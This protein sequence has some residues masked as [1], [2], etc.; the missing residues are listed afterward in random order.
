MRVH[1]MQY[2]MTP[3]QADILQYY[4]QE[5]EGIRKA[6]VHER[7]MDAT[8]Y[9]ED[10]CRED[11]VRALAGFQYET[12]QVS[13]PEHTGRMLRREFEDKMF[14]L[15]AGRL[16]TRFLLPEPISMIYTVIRSVPFILRGLKTLFSGKLEVPVLDATSITVSML[17]GDFGTAGDIM[18][19]L[20]IGALLEDWTHR[21]SVDDLAQRMYLNV[22]KVWLKSGESEVLVPVNKVQPGD[23]IIVRT[24]NV[25]P[26]DG[27]VV[28]GEASVNQASMTGESLPVHKQKGGY[29]YA[30]TV[31]EEGEI[32]VQVKNAM[33]FGRYDKIVRMIEDSEKLK[34][35][36]ASRAEHLADKLVPWSLGFTA[37]CWLLTRNVMKT[38]SILMVD[39]SCALKLAMPISVMSAMRECSDHQINVKG[40]KFL[41][42]VSEADTIV[43]DKT[44]TLTYATPRVKDIITFDGRS[45]TEM[46]RLAACLEEH[47]PHSIANAVVEEARKR[48]ISHKEMHA[49]VEYV[50]A[51]GI[52]SSVNDE[53]VVIGS[54][55]FVL[56]DEHCTFP[57]KCEEQFE[58][59]FGEC[60]L[61]YVAIGG[62]LAAVICIEDPVRQEAAGVVEELHRLGIDKVVMMTGDSDRNAKAVA[63]RIGIDE[64]FS[65]VLPEDKAEFVKAEHAKGRKVIMI[66]DGVNDS[67]ALSEADAG[68]AVS[69]GA[70]IAREIA[71]I[72]ISSS[73]LYE[74]VTLRRISDA[75]VKRINRNY[76]KIMVFNTLLIILGVT[77][78][79]MP[80][81]TAALHNMSTVAIALSSMTDLLD[82]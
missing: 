64:Y 56:E 78:V 13:V 21:K 9:Y 18:F 40:G 66:G 34:S 6:T 44:G 82:K 48:G 80:G 10:G 16:I 36:S 58:E 71:D 25:I 51:H 69:A 20:N 37:L 54:R 5:R 4:L 74:L 22:D 28:S 30:G 57:E 79:M 77:G 67:P 8:I 43:F 73:D 60:S 3:E 55:H 29:V 11:A 76:R 70:A 12:C 63:S 33:G 35:E 38:L 61:L 75:L 23:E 42:A 41:E 31:L 7:T 49:K 81:T 24:G 47:F 15:V 46:L 39:Y 14:G 32:T 62:R 72:T 2:R 52:A 65:E 1:V 68:V 53:R 59:R 26:L 17:H 45:K 27:V 19:L 50:I